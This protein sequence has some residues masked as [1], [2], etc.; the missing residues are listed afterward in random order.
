MRARI[1]DYIYKIY[2][3]YKQTNNGSAHF[4]N[5]NYRNIPGIITALNFKS[6]IYSV[7]STS[8]IGYVRKQ[9]LFNVKKYRI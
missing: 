9:F 3:S 1:G 4:K 6:R 5:E 2:R 7:F 8:L